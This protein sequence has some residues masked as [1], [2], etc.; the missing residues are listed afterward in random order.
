VP[1]ALIVVENM[2]VPADPRVRAQSRTLTAAGWDVTVLCPRGIDRDTAPYEEIDGV[3]VHRYTPR[4]SPGGLSGYAGEYFQALRSTRKL[5]RRLE[6]DGSFDVV[7]VCNP[8]DVMPLAVLALRRRGAATIFDHHDL[9]PE[10][11]E[12]RFRRRGLLHRATLTAER[13]AYRLSD[14]VVATNESF[15]ENALG[16][17]HKQATDV[18]VVRNGPDTSVFRPV[19]PDPSLRRDGRHLIG[20]AGIIGPQ[21]G[22]DVALDALATLRERRQDWTAVFA[23]SG[24]ALEAAREQC[25]QL[26]LDDVVAFLGFVADRERLVTILSTCDVALSPEPR[27]GLNE[28]STLI[29]VSEYLAVGTPVVAFDLPETRRTAGENAQYAGGDTPAAFADAIDE[30]LDNEPRRQEMSAGGRA[31]AVE[32][33]SWSS[34]EATLLDAYERALHH[35]AAEARRRRRRDRRGTRLERA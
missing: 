2:S 21:D 25:S 34:S 5:A 24:D 22:I 27:N 6:A 28:R 16:R 18:F 32:L 12:S 11:F 35:P 8:P 31:R 9:T 17:G 19:P 26:G 4:T 20:C 30:L 14:V 1:R 7:Q 33:L 29:K 10:L 13:L 23:G 3:Q 15:R